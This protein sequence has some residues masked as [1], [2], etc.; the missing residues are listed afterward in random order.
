MKRKEL[1][2]TFLMILNSK[3]HFDLN[4][5][6][7]NI[8]ALVKPYLSS[9]LTWNFLVRTSSSYLVKLTHISERISWN[10]SVDTHD[11]PYGSMPT[12]S[13]CRSSHIMSIYKYTNIRYLVCATKA[14]SVHFTHKQ[15]LFGVALQTIYCILRWVIT[16][17]K[18]SSIWSWNYWQSRQLWLNARTS[19]IKKCKIYL[20]MTNRNIGYLL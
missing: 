19:W 17:Y 6:Y 1:T 4:E 2:N 3:R 18:I 5:L 13:L 14:V 12:N 16:C 15:I 10:S 20:I 8:S 9:S 11:V 7:K